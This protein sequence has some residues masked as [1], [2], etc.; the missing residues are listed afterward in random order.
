MLWLMLLTLILPALIIQGVLLWWSSVHVNR[1]MR[2]MEVRT[3]AL[4]R[5]RQAETDRLLARMERGDRHVTTEAPT[6]RSA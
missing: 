6:T 4:I 2:S 5:T 1:L 3:G